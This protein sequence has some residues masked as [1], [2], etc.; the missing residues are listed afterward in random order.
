MAMH[1]CRAAWMIPIAVLNAAGAAAP[2]AP[3][4]P[5]RF[6]TEASAVVLD[7]VVR[8]GRG[9]PVTGLTRDAFEVFEGRTRQTITVF[10]GPATRAPASA[11]AD[12]SGSPARA[13]RSPAAGVTPPRVVAL[14]FEQLGPAARILAGTAAHG[15]VDALGPGD[16]AGVFVVDRA[17][18]TIATYAPPHAGVALAIDRA[19]NR[20]GL[21][22]R[23]AGKVPGAEFGSVTGRVG[24]GPPTEETADEARRTRGMATFDALS[25][26]VKGLALLPGRK[27]VVL[28]SEGFALD[29]PE[30]QGQIVRTHDD[31]HWP[32]DGRFERFQHLLE[33]ANAAQ[34]AFYTFDAAGLRIEGLNETVAF[35]RAPYVGLKAMADGT[36]GAFVEN[37]NDL[38]PGVLR[39]A[40]DQA[41]YYVL[42]FTSTKAPD[43][44]YR[45]LK[46]RV[47]CDG[48][49]VL[50]RRGYRASPPGPPRQL[51][52]RDVA[53]FLI[54]DG[55]SSPSNLDATFE[56]R[57]S[58]AS[59]PRGLRVTATLPEAA[60]TRGGLVTFLA[61]VKDARGRVS[62]VVSQ[63][64]ELHGTGEP[65]AHL[66]FERALPIPAGRGQVELVVYDHASGRATVLRRAYDPSQ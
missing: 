8:D 23:R 5:P 34:V 33:E 45:D 29:Q 44:E 53:P 42:G 3:E 62:A 21:P 13:T 58:T 47:A 52:L 37:T 22:L 60:A 65:G 15:L 14:V 54:L 43:G 6:A 27:M 61:R 24:P 31:D 46:V 59:A 4:R 64:V 30:D 17:V 56:V 63:H 32:Q 1:A 10:E 19:A 49:R 50:A 57:P 7:V 16:F 35:G 36:G 38:V 18:Q 11:A 25:Q 26:I 55:E 66:T 9:R 48:C 40:D 39:A 20:P 51:G 12:A 2:Q 28:F 41:S